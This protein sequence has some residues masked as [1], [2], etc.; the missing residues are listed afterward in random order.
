MFTD[1]KKPSG[2]KR[3]EITQLN[4]YTLRFERMYTDDGE[5]V[6]HHIQ[7]NEAEEIERSFMDYQKAVDSF[8]KE[9]IDFVYS[10]I[11]RQ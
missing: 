8:E 11:M 2:K 5:I 10:P 9:Y 3:T 4:K 7:N 1:Y 6:C